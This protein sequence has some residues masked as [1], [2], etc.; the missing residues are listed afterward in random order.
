VDG[1]LLLPACGLPVTAVLGLS[2]A[3]PLP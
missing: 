2:I 1:W 3:V